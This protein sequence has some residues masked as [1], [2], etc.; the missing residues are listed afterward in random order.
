[1]DRIDGSQLCFGNFWCHDGRR[2][3]HSLQRPVAQALG[4]SEIDQLDT[5]AMVDRIASDHHVLRFQVPVD[6]AT[7]VHVGEPIENLQEDV[8]SNRLSQ[9]SLE[10]N[11]F[12]KLLALH[13]LHDNDFVTRSDFSGMVHTI[14]CGRGQQPSNVVVL[15]KHSQCV[16]LSINRRQLLLLEPGLEDKSPCGDHLDGHRI[17]FF[18]SSSVHGALRSGPQDLVEENLVSVA[19]LVADLGLGNLLKPL[20]K[21]R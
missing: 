18:G 5:A 12:C 14:H 16:E 11:V 20:K 15:P 7:A 9:R 6:D 2:A 10:R 19:V 3:N 21:R 13:H 8:A 17:A 1:M 4:D